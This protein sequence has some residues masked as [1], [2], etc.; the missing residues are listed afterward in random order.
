MKNEKFDMSDV[1]NLLK[2]VEEKFKPKLT[3]DQIRSINFRKVFLFGYDP[4]DVDNT[5]NKLANYV[6]ELLK[7]IERLRKRN[8]N[9][10]DEIL[11]REIEN[12]KRA[13]E[14]LKQEYEAKLREYEDK[15]R[16]I[17]HE[18]DV[19]FTLK[20]NI[21]RELTTTLKNIKS[22]VSH[23]LKQDE[24]LAEKI[25]KLEEKLK[26]KKE[27]SEKVEKNEIQNENTLE[28]K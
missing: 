1:D 13:K 8:P 25:K 15:L 14:I 20:Q 7:E 24:I 17:K 21:T 19:Y 23:T 10:P 3:P 11:R 28:P 12:L 4:K 6:E 9:S 18:I 26:K 5:L 16:K 22:L 2:G 27:S